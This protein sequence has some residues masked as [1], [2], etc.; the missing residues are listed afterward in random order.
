VNGDGG[1]RAVRDVME[2]HPI[3][4]TPETATD[5]A[6]ELMRDADTDCLPVVDGDKLVGLVTERDFVRA[7]GRRRR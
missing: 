4:V 2:A 6:L 5:A 3:A 1:A 7:L